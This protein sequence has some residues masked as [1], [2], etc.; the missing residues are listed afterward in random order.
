[1]GHGGEARLQVHDDGAEAGCGEAAVNRN[2][3][4]GESHRKGNFRK[5]PVRVSQGS[6]GWTF[7]EG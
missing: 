1:M 3:A 6:A 7:T 2:E 4:T 5:L